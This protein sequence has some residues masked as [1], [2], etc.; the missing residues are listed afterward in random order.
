MKK[1][2]MLRAIELRR[3]GCSFNEIRRVLGVGKST[4]SR[5][6]QGMELTDE[7]RRR[8][9]TASILAG[10]RLS[11]LWRE[12]H[13]AV[14]QAYSPPL[15]DAEYMLGIGLYWGEGNKSGGCAVG[16]SN[17]DPGVI[18]SFLKWMHR[19]FR[20]EF[21]RVSIQIHHHRPEADL[22]VKGW[23]SEQ[24]GIAQED[25]RPSI[26]AVSRASKRLRTLEFG[27]AHVTIC[28]RET[29]KIRWKI[30]KALECIAGSA[31]FV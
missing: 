10:K 18:R 14:F 8:F 25:I 2:E 15:S 9:R 7:Q 21:E 20:G 11:E 12:K 17:S 5:W 28:G 3:Q 24:L 30:K 23:W 16:L 29:W 6:L 27:T 4:L 22:E 19:F 13:R 1:Q 31:S 26:F